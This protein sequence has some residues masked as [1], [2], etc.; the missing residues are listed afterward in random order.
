M[1]NSGKYGKAEWSH[2]KSQAKLGKFFLES[3]NEIEIDS[4]RRKL[5]VGRVICQ[6]NV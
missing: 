2:V 6:Q 3:L 1:E 4:S 5:I